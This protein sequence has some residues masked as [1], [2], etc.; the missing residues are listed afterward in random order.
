VIHGHSDLDGRFA[1]VQ[2]SEVFELLL[3][4]H[5]STTEN[6]GAWT[7]LGNHPGACFLEVAKEH[8]IIDVT[9]SISVTPT[10]V[11]IDNVLA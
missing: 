4:Y 11:N 10:Q 7:R 9:K 3:C 8:H 6:G 1:V 5:Q 2:G